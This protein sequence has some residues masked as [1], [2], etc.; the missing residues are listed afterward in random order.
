MTH[1]SSHPR[2]DAVSLVD[3]VRRRA[4]QRPEVRA[5]SFEADDGEQ[6]HLTYAELDLRARS[7]AARLQ[8]LGAARAVLVYPPGL[9]YIVAVFGCL[10]AGTAA[11]PVYP[12]RSNRHASRVLAILE[13]A[14][15]EERRVGK[16]CRS[17]WSPYH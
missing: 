7:I 13:D 2:I 15:S 17:R 4:A 16:E 3:L 12:P 8:L 6:T 5:F 11:V 14:R 9:E 10:Y 1:K